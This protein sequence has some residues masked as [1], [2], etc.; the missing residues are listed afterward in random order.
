MKSFKVSGPC[1]QSVTSL[2]CV[3]TDQIILKIVHK[4]VSIVWRHGSS[5]ASTFD[6]LRLLIPICAQPTKSVILMLSMEFACFTT[7]LTSQSMPLSIPW[8]RYRCIRR[9]HPSV[10]SAP[11]GFEGSASYLVL[12]SAT[13][14]LI[15]Q[16]GIQEF[17]YAAG[18]QVD[19]GNYWV[20]RRELI[21]R[22]VNFGETGE[23]WNR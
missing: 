22:L 2:W 7:V 19:V 17:R 23:S 21:E 18:T 15:L 9:Q 4:K 11:Q 10:P 6:L 20:H 3:F 14:R 8:D 5:H 16:K 1:Q 13:S 12:N